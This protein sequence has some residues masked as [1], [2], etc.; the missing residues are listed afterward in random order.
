MWPLTPQGKHTYIS[1]RSPLTHQAWS[2][3]VNI[4]ITDNMNILKVLGVRLQR[5][6][7]QS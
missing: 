6:N 1:S 3:T 4:Y 7:W 2:Q 5:Y